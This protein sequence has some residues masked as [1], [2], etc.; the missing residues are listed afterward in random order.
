MH[1]FTKAICVLSLLST[2]G[3]TAYAQKDTKTHVIVFGVDGMSTDGVRSARTPHMHRM[4]EEGS[5]TLHAR[6]VLPTSSSPNWASMIMGAGPEQHGVTSNSW[7]R[8][9]DGI[10]PVV[11]G[12][13]GIFPTIFSV[14]RHG[15]PG[16]EIGVIHDWDGFARLVETTKVSYI[17]HEEGPYKTATAAAKYIE[18]KKPDFLF[19]HFDHVDDA[20]HTYSHGSQK[21]YDAVALAD[22]LLG[23]VVEATKKAG[24]YDNTIF[25]VTADHGGVGF[26]HGGETMPELEIPFIVFGKDI[27]KGY[28]IKRPVFTYDNAATIAYI[29]RLP[30]PTAWIGRP[31]RSIFIGSPDDVA[32][33][34]EHYIIDPPVIVSS[35]KDGEPTGGLFIDSIPAVTCIADG[36]Y[37]TCYTIDGREPTVKS[38]RYTGPFALSKTTV[39]KFKSYD[40]AGNQSATANGFFRVIGR[41]ELHPMHYSYYEI[42]APEV[43]PDFKSLT[44]LRTG[45]CHEFCISEIPNRGPNF[46]LLIEGYIYIGQEGDYKFY[47]Q[48]DDGSKLYMDD[49]QIVNN[50]GSHGMKQHSG[51]VTL[52]KG[53]HAIKAT[54]FNGSGGH[55]LNVLYRG[56]GICKQI[57]PADILFGEKR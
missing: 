16:A 40:T 7:E 57:I 22:S 47:T 20:G 1:F 35:A 8:D 33:L 27:K 41:N 52:T 24:T 53:Y 54:Y 5:F 19:L 56:P 43:L 34:T 11:V 23:V 51:D 42:D 48:S 45:T 30:V 21:Y 32:A 25:I 9:D 15:I 12:D 29:W 3:I 10:S 55:V 4:M 50:D 38:T 26:G 31:V 13:E 28:E 6:G 14:V 36:R 18:A 49:K 44:A 2:G 39:V 46:A 37:K 17:S